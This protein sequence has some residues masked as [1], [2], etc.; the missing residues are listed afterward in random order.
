VFLLFRGMNHAMGLT[1]ESWQEPQNLVIL[2][3]DGLI[4]WQG[5]AWSNDKETSL[6]SKHI[7]RILHLFLWRNV[8]FLRQCQAMKYIIFD[9]L[10]IVV[11]QYTQNPQCPINIVLGSDMGTVAWVSHG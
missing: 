6:T 3:Q 8:L 2:K 5:N 4:K 1:A 11:R 10:K 9:P 7:Y